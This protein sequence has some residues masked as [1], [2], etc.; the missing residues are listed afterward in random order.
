MR[1]RTK[2]YLSLEEAAVVEQLFHGHVGD[3][4]TGFALD[5]AFDDVLHMVTSCADS[6]RSSGS[7]LAAVGVTGEEHSV[8]LQRGFVVVGAD[9]EDGGHWN[10]C[11]SRK[12]R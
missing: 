9:G 7:S 2:T 6:L 8:L 11:Q 3:D 10:L 1:R 5:D 12:Q 4:R